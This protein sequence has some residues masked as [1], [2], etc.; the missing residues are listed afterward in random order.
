MKIQVGFNYS[1]GK[2]IYQGKGT[3]EKISNLYENLT[4]HPIDLQRSHSDNFR[5]ASFLFIKALSRRR[6]AN[7]V[8]RQFPVMAAKADGRG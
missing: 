3:Q 1:N 2:W 5:S 7:G 6:R 8:G 4:Y